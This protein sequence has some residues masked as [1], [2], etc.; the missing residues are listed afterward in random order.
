VV[1][2][3]GI[4]YEEL[5]IEVSGDGINSSSINEFGISFGLGLPIGRTSGFS[6]A[7]VGFELGQRGTQ[8]NGLIRETFFNFSVGLSLND[9]WFIKRKYN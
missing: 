8:D 1:Y 6:N 7:N 9:T 2:R 3:G 5:G 4:R